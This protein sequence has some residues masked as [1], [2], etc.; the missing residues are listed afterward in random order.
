MSV[1]A[2]AC[3]CVALGGG[4]V[5]APV[6]GIV[7][8]HDHFTD[9]DLF[10][11]QIEAAGQR[12]WVTTAVGIGDNPSNFSGDNFSNVTSRGHTVI[13]RVNYGFFDPGNLPATGTIPLPARYDE[14]ATRCANFAVATAANM[15]APVSTP[16]H[17]QIGN[18]TNVQSEFPWSSATNRYTYVTPEDY[19]DC[20]R[21]VYNAIKAA[22]PNDVVLPQ[23]LS[24]YAG[25][26][27]ATDFAGVP[28][29]ALPINW[30]EYQYRMMSAIAASGPV[31]GI[32]IHAGSRGYAFGSASDA[33]RIQAG[34]AAGLNLP[35]GSAN[36]EEWLMYATPPSLWGLP[37][38]TTETNG[39]TFWDGTGPGAEPS[40]TTVPV[41][42]AGYLQ[43][44]FTRVNAWNLNVARSGMPVYHC[45]NLY[46]W[47]P[48]DGWGLEG[49]AAGTPAQQ[50]V[51]S[52][53]MGTDLAASLAPGHVAPFPGI[54]ASNAVPPGS[55]ISQG[56]A[57]QAS[58]Q[59]DAN[60]AP[61]RAV[62]GVITGSQKWASA[63]A[64][65]EHWLRVD[66]GAERPVTGF[67]V[68]HAQA[69]GESASFNT[70]MFRVESAPSASGPWSVECASFNYAYPSGATGSVTNFA[71]PSSRQLRHVRLW[72]TDGGDS[73]SIARIP[74]FQV[75]ADSDASTQI[76]ENAD[77]NAAIMSGAWSRRTDGAGQSG[78]DHYAITAGTGANSIE[79]RPVLFNHVYEVSVRHPASPSHVSD[80]EFTVHHAH[81]SET[82]AVDQQSN[83]GTW[84]SLGTFVFE[85]GRHG[86]VELTDESGDA[87]NFVVA[88]AV[89]FVPVSVA[90]AQAWESYH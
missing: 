53:I 9:P 82:I 57:V 37:A 16:L 7:G 13:C 39:L 18:E 28:V 29:D 74:E 21:Q 72:I 52:Q 26:L 85:A 89:R 6:Q 68:H 31:D 4:A 11:D 50:S 19:A 3:I 51:Y 45:F 32:S 36:I 12:G 64:G 86:H 14:F 59:F 30:F 77:F 87:G 81:G 58:S 80:A 90:P 46:R 27:P 63:N 40:F 10:L 55:V 44:L 70:R 69:G 75:V 78:D 42:Q 62:D 35:F 67:R 66:L 2:S 76:I 17:W 20:Y 83:G 65:L 22:R 79:W 73:D 38:Y 71:F 43:A 1:R 54:A 15:G 61:A 24:P 84:V 47:A 48:F 25:P 8:I 34:G 60:S 41:Y 88:D 23:A 33:N 56:A 49:Y 5:A